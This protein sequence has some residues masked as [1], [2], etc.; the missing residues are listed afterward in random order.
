MHV[1]LTE[2]ARDIRKATAVQYGNT[3]VGEECR[4][5]E[6]GYSQHNNETG[7]TVQEMPV[8]VVRRDLHGR[9][10]KQ[11]PCK[12]DLHSGSYPALKQMPV[13]SELLLAKK[14]FILTISSAHLQKCAVI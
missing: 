3:G 10:S 2:G 12:E 13:K 7:V 5:Q 14:P 9:R 8:P 11:P 1:G 6:D 4:E